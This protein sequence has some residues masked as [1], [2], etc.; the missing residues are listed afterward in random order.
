M[1]GLSTNLAMCR[2]FGCSFDLPNNIQTSFLSPSNG[3]KINVVL[4]ACHMLK[5]MRNTFFS[6]QILSYN[7]NTI[8]WEFLQNLVNYQQQIKM[9]IA[10]KLTINHIEFQNHKMKVKYAAQLFSSSIAK[11][12]ELLKNVD[13]FKGVS[14]TINFIN[15]INDL[16]DI[17]NSRT[18]YNKNWKKAINNGNLMGTID[19]L[20]DIKAYLLSIKDVNGINLYKTKR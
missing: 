4:D 15:N 18:L 14:E 6:Y 3:L 17:L 9:K 19:K 11:S 5:L 16:F 12:L 8:K 20:Y 13:G 7:G 10:N 1:D 2:L